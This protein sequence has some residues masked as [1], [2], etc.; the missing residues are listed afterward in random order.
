MQKFH[1]FCSTFLCPVANCWG[2]T[3]GGPLLVFLRPTGPK[4]LSRYSNWVSSPSASLIPCSLYQLSIPFQKSWK[5]SYW[6]CEF[7]SNLGG[8]KASM[9]DTLTLVRALVKALMRAA[10]ESSS[11]DMVN[12]CEMCGTV[13]EQSNRPINVSNKEIGGA[14]EQHYNRPMCEIRGYC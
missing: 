4:K 3:I 5:S 12:E 9:G 8:F 2:C 7:Q 6:S 14:V 1:E 13:G 11:S 10:C